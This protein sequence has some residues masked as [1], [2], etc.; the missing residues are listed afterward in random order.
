MLSPAFLDTF[1]QHW[2]RLRIIGLAICV[3]AP[4]TYLGVLLLIALRGDPGPHLAGWRTI[5]A[6]DPLVLVCLLLAL[7]GLAAP[8]IVSG[9]FARKVSEAATFK[10][11]LNHVQIAHVV[12]CA[13]LETLALLGLVLGFLRP[14][15]APLSL[16]LILATP[17]AY[18]ALVKG[19]DDWR[20]VLE[21]GTWA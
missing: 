7:Q 5:P 12:S 15:A 8:T 20:A 19:F 9:I 16:G 3:G 18:G 13:L 17:L 10:E 21:T 1:R 11:A 2:M 4:L 6:S 14:A